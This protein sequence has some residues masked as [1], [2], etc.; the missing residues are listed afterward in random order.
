MKKM[1]WVALVA[2]TLAAVMALSS[3]A[4]FG[5]KAG[6][7]TKLLSDATYVDDTVTY[8]NA[9]KVDVLTGKSFVTY[10]ENL[11]YFTDTV[12]KNGIP[13]VQHTIYNTKTNSVTYTVDNTATSRVHVK[14]DDMHVGDE[15]YAYFLITTASWNEDE[16]ANI[17]GR[18]TVRTDLYDG[19]GTRVAGVSNLDAYS[20]YD[21]VFDEGFIT[22]PQT[23]G[24]LLYFSGNCYRFGEDGKLNKAFEYGELSDL[25]N[26]CDYNDEYY[27]AWDDYNCRVVFYD[28]ELKEVSS[29]RLPQY[30]VEDVTLALMRNGKLF[31]QYYYELPEDAKKY[32]F[33]HNK[34]VEIENYSVGSYYVDELTKYNVATL[35][36]DAKK[37]KAK[38]IDCDYLIYSIEGAQ[39]LD[40]YDNYALDCEDIEA[41]A[42]DAY[43]IE[44]GRVSDREV[45]V[46]LDKNGKV[47]ELTFNGENVW[48]VVLLSDNRVAVGTEAHIYLTDREGNVIGKIDNVSFFGN[49]LLC[50]DKVYDYDLN[51]KL[52]LYERNYTLYDKGDE[53][54]L[55][56]NADGDILL[57]T[58]DKDP[59]VIVEEDGDYYLYDAEYDYYVLVKKNDEGND[60]Y[61]IYN[62]KGDKI[63]SVEKLPFGNFYEIIE[64]DEAILLCIDQEVDGITENVYYRLT[65]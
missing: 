40:G 63:T 29:Y 47:S 15:V 54:L 11:I 37:G 10:E 4:L 59:Y 20:T 65:K 62:V 2:L 16:D 7:L 21:E 26:I 13:F 61:E 14:L 56:E 27:V 18:A 64:T 51:V 6:D 8:V 1:K 23:A 45:F 5:G 9:A 39:W 38:E 35:M 32:D 48:E 31:L 28:R 25:P 12:E 43:K 36:I 57:Y 49:Y 34:S 33:V 17:V 19:T 46:T 41:M 60:E 53:Y 3:C 52:N 50:G 58:G 30:E 55:L 44:D 22:M 24:D 42:F